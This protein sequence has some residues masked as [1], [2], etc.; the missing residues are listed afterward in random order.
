[1]QGWRDVTFVMNTGVLR[2]AA[3]QQP[4]SLTSPDCSQVAG[5]R[6]LL[7]G[8]NKLCFS[9]ITKLN[10]QQKILVAAGNTNI[11]LY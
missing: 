5:N 11:P 7:T 10:K 8:W 2:G 6:K 9:M 3:A 4:V 1:M